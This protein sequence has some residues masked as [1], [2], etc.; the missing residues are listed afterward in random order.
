[1]ER[2]YVIRHGETEW[3]AQRRMQ[4]RLDS[5][6]TELGRNQARRHGETIRAQGGVDAAFVSPLGRTRATADILNSFLHTDLA[7]VDALM[8]RDCGE[9]SGFTVDEAEARWPDEWRAREIDPFG[10]RPPGGENLVD[11]LDRADSFLEALRGRPEPVI[12]LVTHGVMSRC[13]LTHYLGLDP[14][15]AVRVRHPNAA[16]YVLDFA[17]GGVEACHWLDGEGPH[18]G[19]LDGSGDGRIAMNMKLER[20]GE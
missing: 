11:M 18:A 3:N 20:Q 2:L 19:L 13:V 17:K 5:A 1:V 8:E 10:H 15:R 6:L 4:G 9:W 12:A 14:P 7:Y 16:F